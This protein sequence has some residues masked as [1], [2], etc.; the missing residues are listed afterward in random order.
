MEVHASNGSLYIDTPGL[1]N[2]KHCEV[3]ANDITQALRKR[4]KN[5]DHV[6]GDT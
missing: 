1:A 3:Y 2:P 6:C 4:N 5:E